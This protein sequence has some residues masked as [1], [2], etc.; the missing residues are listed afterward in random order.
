LAPTVTSLTHENLNLKVDFLRDVGLDDN[1]VRRVLQQ[2]PNVLKITV[3][4]MASKVE[5]LK[6]LGSDR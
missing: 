5:G 4:N 1:H 3:E 6:S 2:C